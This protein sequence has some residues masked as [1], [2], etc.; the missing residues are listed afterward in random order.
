[1]VMRNAAILVGCLTAMAS[2]VSGCY[3]PPPATV[4][5]QS[6]VTVPAPT[7]YVSYTPEYYTWDGYE[8]VGVAG[9]QYVYWDGSVWLAAPPVVIGRFH[10]WERYHP[11]WHRHATPYRYGHEPFQRR[12]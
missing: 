3:T 1:M 9:G 4:S 10:G 7:G 6:P 11:G 5:V 12:F 2:L 8:Y